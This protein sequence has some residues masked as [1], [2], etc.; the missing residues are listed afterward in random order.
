[1]KRIPTDIDTL[2][3]TVAESGDTAAIEDFERRFPEFRGELGCRLAMVR[4]LKKSKPAA[5]ELP[6]QVPRFVLREQ[7]QVP[8]RPVWSVALL[9]GLAVVAFCSYLVVVNLPR[10]EPIRPSG[11]TQQGSNLDPR[12]GQGNPT[13]VAPGEQTEP[14]TM[15]PTEQGNPGNPI[16][17]NPPVE[18]PWDKRQSVSIQEAPL[19]DVLKLIAETC[20]LQ[21]ELGPGLENPTVSAH[22][23]NKTGMEMLKELGREHGF[24]PLSQGKGNVL[25][26]PTLEF[27]NPQ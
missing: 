18:M 16:V 9:G 6:H 22:F 21:L 19:N 1:M 24:T 15:N 7:T 8:R 12:Q 11:Q 23:S 10:N 3:W 2:M 27:T 25:I 13:G 17:V 4:G 5:E 14:E 20:K 26:I